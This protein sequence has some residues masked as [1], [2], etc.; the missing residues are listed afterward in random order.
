MNTQEPWSAAEIIERLGADEAL[1]RELV[2]LF[3]AEYPRMIAEVRDSVESCVADRIRRS[4]HALK[5]SVANFTDGAPVH[6]AL[7]LE[8]LARDERLDATE[9][10]FHTLEDEMQ[11]FVAQLE[12]F[13]RS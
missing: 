7:N 9:A 6:A 13:I 1:A 4:A 8:L 12:D 2:S 5:G 11:I 10:A 3:L